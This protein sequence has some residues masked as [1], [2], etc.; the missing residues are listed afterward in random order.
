M[1]RAKE[2]FLKAKKDVT[3]LNFGSN[4]SK[5]GSDGL[6]FSEIR[7][8]ANDDVKKINWK[9][10]ARS[11][12]LKIN[13]FHET[14]QLNIIIAF[15]LSGG[16][17]FGSSRLK[18]DLGAEILALLGL[19]GVYS[20]NTVYPYIFSSKFEKIVEPINYEDGIYALV[21]D[22]LSSDVLG[23][24][25]NFKAL[26]DAINLA[27]KKRSMIFIISDF[28]SDDIDL[29]EISFYNDVYAVC[30]RD[31]AEED[32]FIYDDLNFIDTISFKTF[33][34]SIDKSLANRY[35]RLLKEHDYK[36]QEHFFDNKISFTKIYDGDDI[37]QKFRA[38]M[39]Y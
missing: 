22:V 17:N 10:T 16:L 5:F 3:N 15:I 20:K 26:C 28:L 14:K 27:N 25:P 37:V 33:E 6:D 4:L 12:D 30:I 39:G 38:L 34:A 8:Y 2:I 24:E 36:L 1:Q 7:D 31:I 13:V 18:L 29:S 19:A 23:K 21:D 9:A 11:L 35:S 32:I